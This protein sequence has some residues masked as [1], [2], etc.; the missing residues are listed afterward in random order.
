MVALRAFAPA[1]V[2]LYLHITGLRPDGYHWIDSL[3]AFASIGDD[4]RVEAAESLSLAVEGPFA[5]SLDVDPAHNLVWRAATLLAK[6][7]RRAPGAA[8]TLVKNLPVASGIGGGSSDAAAALR[9][10]SSLWGHEDPAALREI[11]VALGA[12]VPACLAE[13]P[14]QIGGIGEMLRPAPPL[15]AWGIVLVNPNIPLSTA[16]VFRAFRGTFSAPAPLTLERS[17]GKALVRALAERRND[18]TPAALTL[19]PAIGEVLDCLAAAE[20][21][22]LARMSGSGA[23]CFALFPSAAEA[24]LASSRIK[25]RRPEWWTAGGTLLR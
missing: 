3:V 4:I 18:L 13:R 20:G 19:V 16:S 12:D 1:K 22:L 9:M 24:D 25:A 14:I 23:T 2:N 7:L 11:A 8:I 15:P 5:G 10:L 17:E 6:R 21:G